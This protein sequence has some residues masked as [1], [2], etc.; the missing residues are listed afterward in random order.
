VANVIWCCHVAGISELSS[1]YSHLSSTCCSVSG[2]SIQ[3]KSLSSCASCPSQLPLF[4]SM[5]RAG[6]RPG[7]LPPFWDDGSRALQQARNARQWADGSPLGRGHGCPYLQPQY[8]LAMRSGKKTVEGRPHAG[9]AAQVS[10]G[11]WI[12]FKITGTGGKKLHCRVTAV[13]RHVSFEAMLNFH[14]THA[15]LPSASTLQAA[16]QTYRSFGTHDGR[17]YADLESLHGVVGIVV[18]PLRSRPRWRSEV[19]RAW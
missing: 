9:W 15:L 4:V 1:C 17:S 10:V 19:T 13:H 8:A 16:V 5:P 7:S 18:Q 11:D 12:S 6:V 3:N 14:G 2:F